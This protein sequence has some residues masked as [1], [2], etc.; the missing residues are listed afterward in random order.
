MSYVESTDEEKRII[1]TLAS[2]IVNSGLETPAVVFLESI[3]PIA[4]VGSQ[5]AIVVLSP[6]LMLLGESGD[7][8]QKIIELLGK[9]ENIKQLIQ[10]IENLIEEKRRTTKPKNSN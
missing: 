6:F 7:K 4:T 2:R 10:S 9:R 1:Q 3:Y 8:S 5:I